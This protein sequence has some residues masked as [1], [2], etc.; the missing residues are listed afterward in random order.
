MSHSRSRAALV[1]AFIVSSIRFTSGCSMMATDVLKPALSAYVGHLV[2]NDQMV[3]RIHRSLHV[4]TNHARAAP[5][6]RHRAAVGIGER[7]L[8]VRRGEHPLLEGVQ[9]R[10]FLI[11]FCKLF[12][13]MRRLGGQRFRWLLQIGGVELAQIPRHALFE[14]RPAP[15]DLA[16]REVLVAVVHGF[17]FAAVDGDAGFGEK[18]YLAAQFN[19]T[20]A[21]F[22]DRR[23][24]VLAE[25]GDHLV[26]V[27]HGL[28]RRWI[29]WRGRSRGEALAQGWMMRVPAHGE[30][31]LDRGRLARLYIG[32][33][34]VTVVAQQRFDLAQLFG[35]GAGPGQ[36]RFELLLVVGRLNHIARNHQQAAF[37]YDGL[38]VVALLE[39]A[40]RNRH[41]AR[42]FVAVAQNVPERGQRPTVRAIAFE[43]ERT[44]SG[45]SPGRRYPN[46]LV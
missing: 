17:E 43:D 3:L 6:R 41:D 5:A 16:T 24:V 34:E 38:S 26:T 18:P 28:D 19:E 33:A 21:R 39:A 46:R 15:F 9:L 10:H 25:I 11:E 14:L 29:F 1:F 45:A 32:L 40:A 36:H 4:V 7:D 23:T 20:R 37:R 8:L 35:Q 2:R 13:E 30:Q 31:R 44:G 27:G 12:L 42:F 22:A